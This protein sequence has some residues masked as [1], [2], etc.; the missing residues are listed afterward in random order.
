MMIL[1][2]EFSSAQRSVAVLQSSASAMTVSEIVETGSPVGAFQMS[3]RALEGCSL[4]REQVELIAVGLGP[5]S[6]TGIRAALALAQGWHLA[7]GI[8][9]A[10]L[11]SVE[12]LAALAHAENLRGSVAVVI[13]AQRNEFYLANYQLE[14][15]GYREKKPLR[16]ALADEVRNCE[17]SG[18]VLLGPEIKR[19]FPG[20]RVLFPSAATVARLAVAHQPSV[21]PER[22]QPI[23]LR[24]TQFVK[25]AR[26]KF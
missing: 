21:S 7:T 16:L 20:G 24:E 4:E 22:L 1:A 9:V 26:P 5:G 18:E 11:S 19:W 25:A 12:C 8:R 13:D 17:A 6:Y 10:G 23:Y 15:S 3:E 14:D 2:V